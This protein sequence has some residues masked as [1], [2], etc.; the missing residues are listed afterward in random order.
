MRP[1]RTR[2]DDLSRLRTPRPHNGKRLTTLEIGCARVAAANLLV[3][4]GTVRL[5]RRRVTITLQPAGTARETEAFEHLA[6]YIDDLPL[7]LPGDPTQRRL[8]VR[9]QQH[10]ATA[11]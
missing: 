11:F 9:I 4:P 3:A 7:S 1:W 8:H 6:R 2:T 5:T 10:A